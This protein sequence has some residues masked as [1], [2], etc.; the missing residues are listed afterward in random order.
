MIGLDTNVLVRFL[1]RDDEEQFER[2]CDL[3]QSEA[4]RE[5]FVCVSLAVLLETDG[6]CEADTNSARKRS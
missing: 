2:A 3:I 5:E 6:F 4:Q 1:I